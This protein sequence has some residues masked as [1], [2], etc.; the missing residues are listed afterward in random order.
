MEEKLRE[1]ETVLRIRVMARTRTLRELTD[2]LEEEV[3]R[4]TQELAKEVKI[5]E[6]FQRLTAGRVVRLEELRKRNKKLKQE[7]FSLQHSSK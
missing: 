7:L 2:S 3:K 1:V 4:R 5:L 6:K